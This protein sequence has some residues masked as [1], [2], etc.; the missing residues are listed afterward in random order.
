MK[1]TA[2]NDNDG[3][4]WNFTTVLEDIDFADDLA[5]L[6]SKKKHIQEKVDRLCKHGKEIGMKSSIKKTKLMRYNAMY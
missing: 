5:L 6:S 2:E 4:K 1:K 3:I